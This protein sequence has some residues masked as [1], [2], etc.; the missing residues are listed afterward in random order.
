MRHEINSRTSSSPGV[1]ADTVRLL[2]SLAKILAL[3]ASAFAFAS[4]IVPTMMKPN[5]QTNSAIWVSR[6]LD[7]P[8]F[9]LQL[10]RVCALEPWHSQR[11]ADFRK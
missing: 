10:L 11:K 1:I 3:R 5:E 8:N 4:D 9:V 7:E 6:W 2:L